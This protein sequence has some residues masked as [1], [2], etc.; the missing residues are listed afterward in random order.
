M[1]ASPITSAEQVVSAEEKIKACSAELWQKYQ[2]APECVRA[3]FRLFI[4]LPPDGMLA[5]ATGL[6]IINADEATEH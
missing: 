5:V 3:P 6:G 1:N 2:E 4:M